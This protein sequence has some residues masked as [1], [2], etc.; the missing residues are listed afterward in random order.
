MKTL[1]LSFLILFIAFAGQVFGQVAINTTGD[2][3]AS[4]AMLDVTST[5]RGLLIPRMTSLQR[6]SLTV[7]DGLMVFQT[8]GSKG[9]YYYD[10]T[11]ALWKQAGFEVW[12]PGSNGI[13]YSGNVGIG[14]AASSV[15]KLYTRAS[16]NND[17]VVSFENRYDDEFAQGLK[18]RAG[19]EDGTSSTNTRFIGIFQGATFKGG[20]TYDIG[21]NLILSTS[22]D[23]RLKKDIIE[24]N[25]SINDLLKIKVRDFVWIN[26]DK[27]STGFIAQE[28]F[29]VYPQAVIVPNDTNE[30]L[31]ISPQTLIPLIV[32][33]IQDQQSI[34]SSQDAKIKSLEDR[35]SAIEQSL[36][37]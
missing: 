15:Q 34:I 33:S 19:L 8:D 26:S 22:S 31:T 24:S 3:P 18:I 4:S 32:K 16:I 6:T 28:L 1:K 23:E 17:Y 9:L 20:I 2:A 36:A 30:Y 29:E 25:V 11:A 14:T 10:A 37:K 7:V 13:T 12:T 27:S 5:T 21:G 35:I